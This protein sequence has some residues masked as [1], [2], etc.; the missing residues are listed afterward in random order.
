M[1]TLATQQTTRW[2]EHSSPYAN[3]ITF[4]QGTMAYLHAIE[5]RSPKQFRFQHKPAPPA[6]P[7]HPPIL[8][9][10]SPHYIS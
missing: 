2:H 6:T 5:C 8:A 7:K 4:R 3:E 10:V 1:N 9:A